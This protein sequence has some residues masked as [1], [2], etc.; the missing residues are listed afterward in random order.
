M[1]QYVITSPDGKKYRITAPEGVSKEEADA[2]VQDYFQK[3]QGLEGKSVNLKPTVLDRA[4]ANRDLN[5]TMGRGTIPT[6]GMNPAASYGSSGRFLAGAGKAMTDI[7]RGAGQR[8]GMVS[9]EDVDESKRLDRPLMDTTGGKAGYI[10]GNMASFL[11]ALA[12]PGVNT[13]GGSALLGAGMGALEPTATGE[14]AGVNTA[15][16]AMLG[17]GTALG[18]RAAP[19]IAKA[20]V[21]PFRGPGREQIVGRTLQRFGT[22]PN[23]AQAQTPGWE[24]TLAEASGDPGLAVLQRGAG[25]ASPDVA[26]ALAQRQ[27]EQNAAAVNAVRR[28]GGTAQQR[29]M[30]EGLRSYMTQGFYDDAMKTG[31]DQGMAKA[32]RPQIENLMARPS[33]KMAI[34]R[35]EG[36]MDEKSIARAMEG[37]VEGLQLIKQ[38]MDDSISTAAT[39]S[40]GKNQLNALRDTRKDLI[41]IMEQIAPKLRQADQ[42]YA[43]FSRPIN[44]MAV[45]QELEKKLVPALMDGVDVPSK[46][47]GQEFAAALRSLDDRIPQMTGFQGSTVENT[48]SQPNLQILEG[49]KSDLARRATSQE[50]ARGVGSNTAQNLATQNIMRQGMGPLG[51]PNSWAEALSSSVLGRTAAS[52]LGLIYNRAAERSI[53][54]QLAQ[55]LMDPAYAQSLVRNINRPPL[56]PGLTRAGDMALGA[57]VPG[58]VSAAHAKQ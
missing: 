19:Q 21:D 33:I 42:N 36:I 28:I 6:V 55:A 48:L 41:Q 13:V 44:E 49:I 3:L 37:D 15:K 2:Y 31:V 26:A 22:R 57:V 5:E 17:G 7:A 40:I 11:P 25:S 14:S 53:Q 39:S 27:L 43:I 34:K 16:G 58:V 4:L 46:V 38:A 10:A 35:A 56:S 52:P 12:I 47:R 54:E 8:A 1:T 45:G 50:A 29:A 23:P 32:L 51:M 24:Q 30:A 18:I 9:Q 20:L